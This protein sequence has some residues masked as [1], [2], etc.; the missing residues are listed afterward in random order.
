MVCTSI[1]EMLKFQLQYY[2]PGGDLLELTR[3]MFYTCSSFQ[4]N[5]FM[6]SI[7]LVDTGKLRNEFMCYYLFLLLL[8]IFVLFL[9]SFFF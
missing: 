9:F 7:Y 8:L 6:L 5:I 3:Q 2:L 1:C 4:V